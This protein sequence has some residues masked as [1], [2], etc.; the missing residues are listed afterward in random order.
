MTDL[1]LE[2]LSKR[3]TVAFVYLIISSLQIKYVVMVSAGQND[4]LFYN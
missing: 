4:R 3:G 2:R 1:D